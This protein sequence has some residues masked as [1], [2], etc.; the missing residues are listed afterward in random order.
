MWAIVLKRSPKDGRLS[1]SWARRRRQRTAELRPRWINGLI[2]RTQPSLISTIADG[3]NDQKIPCTR[4]RDIGHAHTF[5]L[6][7]RGFLLFMIQ[8]VPRRAAKN[9][10][11]SEP[12]HRID[13]PARRPLSDLRRHV[14][15][16]HYRKLKPIGGMD[17]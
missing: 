8:Q 2:Q 11:G 1:E 14:G 9:P 6:I 15:K 4:S 3:W 13:I 5:G 10:N 16:N 12:L 17:R 7:A